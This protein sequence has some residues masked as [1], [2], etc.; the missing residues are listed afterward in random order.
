MIGVYAIVAFF[1]GIFLCAV[2]AFGWYMMA[3]IKRL[4]A[5][6]DLQVKSTQE[7]LG[8]GSFTRISKSLAAISGSMPEMMQGM[9]ILARA[10]CAVVKAGGGEDEEAGGVRQ[11]AGPHPPSND[12]SAFYPGFTDK[13]AAVN[14]VTAEAHRQKLVISPEELAR[15]HTDDKST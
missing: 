4:T 11:V 15:M 6:V 10:M 2:A 7:L 1:G 14:E 5:A 13:E 12:E 8:E 3:M 9:G